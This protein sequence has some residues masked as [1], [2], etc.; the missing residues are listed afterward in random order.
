MVYIMGGGMRWEG[1]G[2]EG[3][4]GAFT[5]VSRCGKEVFVVVFISVNPGN[6]PPIVNRYVSH[7]CLPLAHFCKDF[8]TGTIDNTNE[9]NK[10]KQQ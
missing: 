7:S 6:F 3:R 8:I 4:G 5:I 2:W 1:G 9:G 10:T